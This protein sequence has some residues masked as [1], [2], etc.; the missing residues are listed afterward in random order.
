MLFD[1]V[2]ESQQSADC[3]DSYC[4]KGHKSKRPAGESGTESK[5]KYWSLYETTRK[6]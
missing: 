4:L 6:T 2:R 5:D 3:M 1:S